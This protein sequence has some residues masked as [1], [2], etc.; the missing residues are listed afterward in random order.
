VDYGDRCKTCHGTATQFG[1]NN[2][3]MPCKDCAGLGFHAATRRPKPE[4]KTA[5]DTRG[6]LQIAQRQ[7]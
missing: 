2:R 4:R 7:S 6:M 3:P 5:V 1:Y